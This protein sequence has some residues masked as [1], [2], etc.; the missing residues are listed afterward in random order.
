MSCEV[1]FPTTVPYWHYTKP[2]FLARPTKIVFSARLHLENIYNSQ[3][4]LA[5]LILNYCRSML[6]L[7]VLFIRKID[8][9]K[10]SVFDER[11]VRL[12]NQFELQ[13]APLRS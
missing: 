12:K 2:M 8:C 10:A 9:P 13:I 4:A 11:R 7:K 3:V 1:V 6:T 5:G